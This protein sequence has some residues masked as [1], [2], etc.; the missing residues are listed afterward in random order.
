MHMAK[1][2][3]KM[4]MTILI[5]VVMIGSVI[6]FVFSDISM[7]SSNSLSYNGFSFTQTSYGYELKIAGKGLLFNYLPDQVDYIPVNSSILEPLKNS[8][9]AYITSDV[10][11][12]YAKEIAGFSYTVGQS[13]DVINSYGQTSFISSNQYGKPV[14]T[15]NDATEFV[16][17][18]FVQKAETSEISKE[19]YCIVVGASSAL[20]VERLGDRLA[21]GILGVVK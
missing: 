19:G 18:I 21:F 9:M 10:N 5:V 17:V 1:N 15:C 14:I 4:I 2:L 20:D 16:P 8:K 7:G 13:L 12:S 3:G 11:S 6:G